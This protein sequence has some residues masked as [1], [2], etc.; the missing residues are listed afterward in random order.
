MEKLH[1]Q[2]EYWRPKSNKAYL[3]DLFVEASYS[4]KTGNLTKEMLRERA[5]SGLEGLVSDLPADAP[6][7]TLIYML[8]KRVAY[9]S[10]L[11]FDIFAVE[12]GELPGEESPKNLQCVGYATIFI[13]AL[14]KLGRYDI[15]N[16][17]R[18]NSTPSHIWL[19][20]E[21]KY[22]ININSIGKTSERK[23]PPE[24]LL[25]ENFNVLAHKLD[26]L[27][28]YDE[29]IK[30]C[31]AGISTYP[32]DFSVWHHKSQALCQLN[33][34]YGAR[35]CLIRGLELNPNSQI[36]K[37]DLDSIEKRIPIK[38]EFNF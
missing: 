20:Y 3:F 27:R 28:D 17:I 25:L 34:Y 29:V 8:D 11:E 7:S 14:E 24:A 1:G 37:N 23:M 26:I 33:D 15:L 38:D 21:D 4:K 36:L 5:L 19:S 22:D 6:A 13:C 30:A 32:A 10:P 18:I 12:F 35:A 31:D 9:A 2:F 16:R